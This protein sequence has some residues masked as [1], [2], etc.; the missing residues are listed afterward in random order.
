ML[1]W[2]GGG[3]T[4]QSFVRAGTLG[5]PLMVAIIGGEIGRL[6][7]LVNLYRRAGEQ[8]GHPP[9]TLKV[10]LH[11]LGFVA[12]TSREAEDRFFAGWMEML[13]KVGRER[14]WPR[15]RES[16]PASR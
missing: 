2:L 10:G 12:E 3:G 16:T 15:R 9:D 14:V 6:R 11:A 5:L 7:P 1:I 13:T 4:P 8:A